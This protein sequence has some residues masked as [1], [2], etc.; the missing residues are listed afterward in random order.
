MFVRR[1]SSATYFPLRLLIFCSRL[2]FYATVPS[3]TN[4][5]VPAGANTESGSTTA[6]IN[7]FTVHTKSSLCT[8]IHRPS[9][10]FTA[11]TEG[12]PQSVYCAH[13]HIGQCQSVHCTHWYIDLHQNFQVTAHTDTLYRPTS[14]YS[15]LA[16]IHR[17]TSKCSLCT[18]IHFSAHIDTAQDNLKVFTV[19]TDTQVYH[20]VHWA[21]KVSVHCAHWYKGCL[22]VHCA[23]FTVTLIHRPISKCSLRTLIHRTTSKCSLRTINT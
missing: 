9:S 11:H 7:V 20:G 23:V 21:H 15:L 8:L 13:W 10:V 3:G 22:G 2:S 16:L 17:P 1:L 12:L 6:F 5:V 14:K 4:P 18:L 19:H